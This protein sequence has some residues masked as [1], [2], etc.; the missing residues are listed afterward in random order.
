MDLTLSFRRKEVVIDKPPVSQLLQ[1][2]PA[3]VLESQVYQEFS[4][5]VGKN[6]KQEFYA[7]LLIK[8]RSHRPDSQ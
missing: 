6:L 2:W 1:R 5:V 7:N 3:L 8:E 4:R